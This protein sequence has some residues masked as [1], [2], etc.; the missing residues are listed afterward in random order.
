[1]NTY[2]CIITHTF[3]KK[4]VLLHLKKKSKI[5]LAELNFD[6]NNVSNPEHTAQFLRVCVSAGARHPLRVHVHP[7][8]ARPLHDH[9]LLLVHLRGQKLSPGHQNQNLGVLHLVPHRS[10]PIR[11][12]SVWPDRCP[13]RKS[14]PNQNGEKK[15]QKKKNFLIKKFFLKIVSCR[16]EP[17][18]VE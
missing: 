13:T 14:F 15:F 3:K 9:I 16:H 4:R 5:L 7:V 18:R 1:M 11:A 2:T 10:H 6:R 12:L 17:A 8:R